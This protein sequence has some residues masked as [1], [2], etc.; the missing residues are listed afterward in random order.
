MNDEV[1]T[2]KIEY[3]KLF[4]VLVLITAISVSLNNLFGSNASGELMRWFM[5]MFFLTFGTFK[6]IGYEM[7]TE[8]FPEYDIIAARSRV[9]TYAYPFIELFLGILYLINAI[10]LARDL[11]TLVISAV[12][13]YGIYRS[14]KAHGS[15]QCA[16]LGNI[17]KLPLSTVS[18]AENSLMAVMALIMLII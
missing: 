12:S 3:F 7:F 13:A 16:C 18:L 1:S 9:Y 5:G 2:K 8:M 14:I 11:F 4:V 6:F 15:I 10:P 17:I